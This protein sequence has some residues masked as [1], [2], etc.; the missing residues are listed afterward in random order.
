LSPDGERFAYVQQDYNASRLNIALVNRDGDE[1]MLTDFPGDADHFT[2]V[3]ELRWSPDGRKL[4][5]WMYDPFS[6]NQFGEL[7]KLQTLYI[8]DLA[9]GTLSNTC[10]RID[11]YFEMGL[12]WSPDSSAL[13]YIFKKQ[14][15]VLDIADGLKASFPLD[16]SSLLGW[17]DE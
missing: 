16:A 11:G 15:V 10:H 4:A 1:H 6:L 2:I 3:T 14:L 7:P 9:D 8:F 5:F 12:I 13:A 17:L